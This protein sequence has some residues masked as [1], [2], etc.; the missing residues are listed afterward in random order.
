MGNE[1][2]RNDD[3][4][5][6]V[7]KYLRANRAFGIAREFVTPSETLSPETRSPCET[8][9]STGGLSV[10]HVYVT[11]DCPAE[12]VLCLAGRILLP[13]TMHQLILPRNFL[14]TCYPPSLLP[15]TCQTSPTTLVLADTVV[16]PQRKLWL[17]L[18]D[19]DIQS[20]IICFAASVSD[21]VHNI[22]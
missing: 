19:T 15:P 11:R 4:R 8:R 2:H 3:L 12:H 13:A 1:N 6:A 20:L 5:T 7:D 14:G 18:Q 17:L 16:P 9:L 10:F 22:P 21:I